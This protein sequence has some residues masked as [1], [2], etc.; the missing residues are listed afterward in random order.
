MIV[1][2][3]CFP[4][5]AHSVFKRQHVLSCKFAVSACIPLGFDL[6]VGAA[7]DVWVRCMSQVRSSNVAADKS[8]IFN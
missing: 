6:V 1:N 2:F 4:C 8:L 5:H 3:A 7:R